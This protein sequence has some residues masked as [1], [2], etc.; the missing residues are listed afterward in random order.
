M[1]NKLRQKLG[2]GVKADE[3]LAPHTT[4]NIG[5]PAKYFFEA[6]TSDAL[7]KAINA[8]KEL[9][10]NYFV[11]GGGS[12]ILIADSGFD[13]LI[14]KQ[15]NSHFSI[16]GD[17]IIAEGGALW[18]EILT[19]SLK[20]SLVGWP[21]AS[22]IPGTIGGAIRGN[23]GAFGR[24]MADVTQAIE[25]YDNG[26]I[27]KISNA[28]LAF[29]YR[30]SVIKDKPDVVVLK[31][32]IKLKKGSPEEVKTDQET[33]VAYLKRRVT[34]QPTDFPNSGCVFKN[35]DLKTV[36]IDKEKVLRGLDVNQDEFAEATKFGKLP[37][38]FVV[39]HLGL[40]GKRIGGAQVSEKHAAFINNV[41]H[42]KAEE[43]IMLISDI[44]MRAR[45]ELGIQ[46][47][48][49]IQYVGF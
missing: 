45:D 47:Q 36:A 1:I 33:V 2:P 32:F 18:S 44:K 39:D 43:V 42:A 34:T 35:I 29:A 23:A 28:E 19:A 20:A 6:T 13:G 21:W 17:E 15:A 9:K 12:N 25:V 4:Y 8:A 38:S 41:D 30:H 46:L 16:A 31:V 40:K 10:I 22:G 26:T 27:K 24:G 11:L 49:E 3:I 5:G 7:V 48:E 14:I 37:S